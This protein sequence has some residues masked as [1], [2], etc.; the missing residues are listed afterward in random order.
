MEENSRERQIHF[1]DQF[2]SKEAIKAQ[3]EKER[4]PIALL[5]D[6][7]NNPRNIG[8]IF[9][10][11]EAA[12]LHCI[13]SINTPEF[14]DSKKLTKASRSTEKYIPHHPLSSLNELE[15]LKDTYQIIGLEITTHSIPYHQFTPQKPIL[16]VLGSEQHGISDEVL[17]LIDQCIHIPMFGIKTSMNV[18]VA[19][20]I[21]VY[22]LLANYNLLNE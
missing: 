14:D 7:V 16:L 8:V 2:K 15:A 17:T 9:R 1:T 13:Y 22:G 4:F 19:A 11:A 20:G 12:R 5:L 10:L 3:L 21:G 18:A 6:G